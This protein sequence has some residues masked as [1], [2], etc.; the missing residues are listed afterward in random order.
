MRED[1]PVCSTIKAAQAEGLAADA[2]ERRVWDRHGTT[3][4]MLAL[5]SAGMTRVTRA[6]GIVHFLACFARMR[7]VVQAV[8]ERH[9]CR[10]WRSFADNLFAELPTAD[11]ALGAA[12]EIHRDLVEKGIRLTEAEPYTVTVAVGFGPVL[13]NGALGV[14]GDEMNLVAKLAEDIGA[15]G[16]TLLTEA[17][18]RSLTAHPELRVEKLD[19][20]VSKIA[21]S[22]YRVRP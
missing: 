22:G 13:D 7:D 10:A 8:L 4:A 3:C 5:D 9:G 18:Y 19:F 20:V 2:V 16:E 17:G 21:F 1:S 15:P 12:L 14:L 6:Q 11:A